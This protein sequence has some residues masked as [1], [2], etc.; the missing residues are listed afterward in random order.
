[1]LKRF[2][3]WAVT[4][5]TVALLNLGCMGM[6]NGLTDLDLEM[7]M[8]ENAVH[9]ADFLV[10]PPA[11]GKKVLSMGMSA[12]ADNL[13]LPDDVNLDIPPGTVYRMEL[14]TYEGVD[15]STEFPAAKSRL[16]G[17]DFEL[18]PNNDDP[19][20]AVYIRDAT[21]FL[22]VTESTDN[23]FTLIRLAPKAPATTP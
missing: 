1:M 3:G 5:G 16:E 19:D 17:A 7:A 10:G 13:N 23:S 22:V 6:V 15:L 2:A 8:E 20:V 12:E 21:F 14:I 18:Q 9:P 11:S 4:L